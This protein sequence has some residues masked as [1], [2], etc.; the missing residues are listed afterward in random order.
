MP[1]GIYLRTEKIREALRRR[2]LP[3]HTKEWNENI[4]KSLQRGEYRK[5]KCGEKFYAHR[6]SIKL[7]WG[8]FCSRQCAGLATKGKP[9][10]KQ[11]KNNVKYSGLHMWAKR[12]LKKPS[13]CNKCNEK[14]LLHLANKSHKYKRDLTDWFWL[15]PP[16]HSEYDGNS[17]IPRRAE[18][19]ILKRR[20]GG[21]TFVSIAKSFGVDR[22][23]I[24]KRYYRLTQKNNEEL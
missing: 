8:K 10:L 3:P 4:R 2:K 13:K 22:K 14:G 16:C 19:E 5:C 1:T 23:A 12:W 11:L 15:C 17:K 6:F 21:E 18:K 24:E 9:K 7:G 20:N